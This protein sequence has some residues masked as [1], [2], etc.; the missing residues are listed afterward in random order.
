MSQ[1]RVSRANQIS[2][3]VSVAFRL[4][5][6]PFSTTPRLPWEEKSDTLPRASQKGPEHSKPEHRAP[7]SIASRRASCA[8]E[9]RTQARESRSTEADKH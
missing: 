8:G 3:H 5:A 6:C 4:H 2:I 1:T 7:A 9:H